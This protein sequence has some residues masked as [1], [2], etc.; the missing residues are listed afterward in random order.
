VIADNA[1][2]GAVDQSISK[3]TNAAAPVVPA[4]EKTSTVELSQ[5][6]G[7]SDPTSL[8]QNLS[9]AVGRLTAVSSSIN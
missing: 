1:P 4:V 3:V 9:T 2:F 7:I 5:A 6:L 8:A